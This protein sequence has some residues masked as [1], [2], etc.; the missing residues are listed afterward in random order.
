MKG[1][2][3]KRIFKIRLSLRVLVG[4]KPNAI[5]TTFTVAAIFRC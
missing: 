4:F 2:E 1:K 5:L 3:F